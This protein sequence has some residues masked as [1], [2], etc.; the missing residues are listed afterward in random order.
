VGLRKIVELMDAV[1]VDEFIGNRWDIDT[2]VPPTSPFFD[3][4]RG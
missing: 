1:P 3:A 4:D 2:A